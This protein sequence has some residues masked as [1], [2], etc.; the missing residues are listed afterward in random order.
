MPITCPCCKSENVVVVCR[1]LV[2]YRIEGEAGAKQDWIVE[3]VCD[4]TSEVAFGQCKDC[5]E[6][7]GVTMGEDENGEEVVAALSPEGA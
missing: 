1:V 6:R 7:L 5:G 4:E 3:E 2:E